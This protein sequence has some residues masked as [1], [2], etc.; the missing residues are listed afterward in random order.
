M[1]L[2]FNF[3]TG[4]SLIV[5]AVAGCTSSPKIA[6][7]PGQ[8]PAVSVVSAG[9]TFPQILLRRPAPPG[10]MNIDK[11]ESAVANG[12][13]KRSLGVAYYGTGGFQAAQKALEDVVL[14]DPLDG[15]AWLYLGYSAMGAGDVDRATVALTKAA[16]STLPALQRAAAFS[17]LGTVQYQGLHDDAKAQDA[18]KK[19]IDLNPKESTASLALGTLYASKN[20]AKSAKR[21]FELA[22]LSL[23]KGPDR[24]S[25]Y[26][27]IGRLEEDTKNMSEAKR[28]Y[29]LA[30]ADDADNAWAKTRLPQ[31]KK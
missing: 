14:N 25:V 24:A 19:A 7:K 23:K 6:G 12:G 18:F 13:S 15:L 26:S 1:L 8:A 21:C 9:A 16:E 3:V 30:L 11:A 17:E 28:Y 22:A 2:K 4:L 20:D 31:I 29:R 10:S 27:C 5:I